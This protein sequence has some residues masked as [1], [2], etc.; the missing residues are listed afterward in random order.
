MSVIDPES[1]ADL[2]PSMSVIVRPTATPAEA[3]KRLSPLYV[4]GRLV[5]GVHGM[6]GSTLRT[7]VVDHML[8]KAV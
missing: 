3:Q 5:Y 4:Y 8:D 2:N 6:D 7:V 1:R